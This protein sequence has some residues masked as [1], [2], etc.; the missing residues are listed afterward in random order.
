M[1][2]QTTA[3]SSPPK[4]VRTWIAAV[5]AK[6]AH[7]APGSPWENGHIDSFNACLHDEIRDNKIFCSLNGA[8][9]IIE[10]WRR[11]IPCVRLPLGYRPTA[12]EV[13]IP[14]NSVCRQRVSEA[15]RRPMLS[16][17]PALPLN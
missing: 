3:R 13:F 1:F 14:A 4:A 12:P 2:G 15:L 7:I 11:A 10:N 8:K 17:A 9:I 5:G 6:T 16:L